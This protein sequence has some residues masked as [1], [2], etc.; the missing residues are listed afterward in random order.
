MYDHIN[1]YIMKKTVICFLIL[2]AG[3]FTSMA[4]KLTL[5]DILIRDP[6]IMPVLCGS[7]M[8]LHT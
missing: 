4:Q 5:D 3:V 6:F 7:R 8:V 2:F 1:S